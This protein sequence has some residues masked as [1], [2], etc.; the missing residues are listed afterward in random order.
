[1][2]LMIKLCIRRYPFLSDEIQIIV[3]DRLV[4][5]KGQVT[6]IRNQ[7]ILLLT[8]HQPD[9]R[10]LDERLGPVIKLGHLILIVPELET[11]SHYCEVK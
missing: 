1:M 2:F 5:L 8:G 7:V 9:C 3:L 11:I 10:F 6:K 4:I